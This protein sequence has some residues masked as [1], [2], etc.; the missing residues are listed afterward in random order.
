[1]A[2]NEL[3]V[4]IIRLEP[5]RVA[6]TYGFGEHP[7]PIAW[8]KMNDFLA[9]TGLLTDG[10]EHRFFGFNN[11]NPA[12]GSPNYGYEQW[13]TI[14]DGLQPPG[15]AKVKTF[16]GGLYAVTRCTLANIGQI[17]EQLFHWRERSPYRF[18]SHQWLE[19]ALTPPVDSLAT[20]RPDHE[21]VMDLYMPVIE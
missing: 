4:R 1:M 15:D 6:S 12:P 2:D 10:G 17:W 16:E 20:E 14:P 3:N 13:V 18:G 9:A 21:T 8:Q 7:E 19:E 11:P 5:M